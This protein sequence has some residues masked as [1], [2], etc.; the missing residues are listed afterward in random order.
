MPKRKR[1]NPPPAGAIFER[2]YQGRAYRLR[3]VD[4]NG[5][6]SFEVG[7]RAFA[8][9]SGAAKSITKHEVNGW[10]FWRIA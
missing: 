10:R 6:R 7:G 5:E 2:E 9:L 8:T 1:R 4:K 3:V